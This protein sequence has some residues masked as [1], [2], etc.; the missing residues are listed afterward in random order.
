[1]VLETAAPVSQP[2]NLPEDICKAGHRKFLTEGLVSPRGWGA[3]RGEA[4]AGRNE[5]VKIH[6]ERPPEFSSQRAIPNRSERTRTQGRN[7]LPGLQG[8]G[9]SRCPRG[10]PVGI[11]VGHFQSR[12]RGAGP[13][14]AGVYSL[15]SP[16][17]CSSVRLS[18]PQCHPPT[19]VVITSSP[20]VTGQPYFK[21]HESDFA[22]WLRK[23]VSVT[24]REPLPGQPVGKCQ[25]Q[26][27]VPP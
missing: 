19:P 17:A 13:V 10:M 26:L 3:R 6:Q 23:M 22:I 16:P 7:V 5:G 25:R 14:Q 11:I 2:K 20:T 4:R 18:Q 12:E 27:G 1:M 9:R 24:Q 15:L 21:S 8:N